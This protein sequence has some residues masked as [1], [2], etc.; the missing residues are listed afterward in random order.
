MEI[1]VKNFLKLSNLIKALHTQGVYVRQPISS[2]NSSTYVNQYSFNK[3][4]AVIIHL[5]FSFR[6][7]TGNEFELFYDLTNDIII[8]Q[9]R[10]KNNPL[11]LGLGYCFENDYINT[12]NYKILKKIN[13][14]SNSVQVIATSNVNE[15]T[16]RGNF[17]IIDDSKIFTVNSLSKIYSE[18]VHFDG[19]S[20]MTTKEYK[21]IK[22]EEES[23]QRMMDD[24]RR[25][26]DSWDEDFPGWNGDR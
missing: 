25:E 20:F 5:G 19:H 7:Q 12:Y 23:H 24:A 1:V 26:V 11:L 10:L 6:I 17:E 21:Q 16:V 4:E 9:L 15:L 22:E 8:R 2:I 13:L 14:V 18:S 3:K